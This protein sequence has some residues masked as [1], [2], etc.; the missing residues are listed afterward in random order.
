MSITYK[1]FLKKN[2][3]LSPVGVER[4]DGGEPYFCTPK[5]AEVFGWAGC[6][7]I[8]YC[9]IKGFGDMVFSVSPM[10]LAPDYVHPL[11]ASLEDFLRLLIVCGDASILEQLHGIDRAAYER[12]C[13]D[14]EPFDEQTQTINRFKTELGLR[15]I[16]DAYGY[17]KALQSDFDYSAIAYSREYYET[18]PID[19]VPNEQPW[20]VYFEGCWGQ[21]DTGRSGKELPVNRQFEWGSEC[22]SVPAVY[23]CSKGLVVD[24]CAMPEQEPLKRY[25]D[26]VVRLGADEDR[27]SQDERDRLERE[28][29]LAIDFHSAVI[30]NGAQLRESTGSGLTYI[31]P[32]LLPE[33]EHGDPLALTVLRHYGLDTDK[34]W[35][36]RRVSFPWKD[37]RKPRSIKTITLSL[38]REPECIKTISFRD[39]SPGDVIS[40]IHPQTGVEHRL[41]VTDS[42]PQTISAAS[43]VTGCELPSHCTQLDYSITPKLPSNRYRL[44]DAAPGDSARGAVMGDSAGAAAI[45]IIGGADGPI[46]VFAASGGKSDTAL[47]SLRYE[48][49]EHIEWRLELYE[50]A[51]EDI[52]VQ[53]I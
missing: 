46:A 1:E 34:A 19:D 48:Q 24:M 3:D 52:E 22:W 41:T 25:I 23:V 18:V 40:F 33:G 7:G 30:V 49:P 11:A 16:E 20:K 17:V 45:G 38:E 50:K 26:K 14:C 44:H 42:E 8:H 39:P 53:L 35:V 21:E 9:F 10:N 31:L 51:V 2:I 5:G 43:M 32:E 29:P 6:D 27:L 28:N 15:P 13:A 4:R 12:L 37:E 47:S 36:L